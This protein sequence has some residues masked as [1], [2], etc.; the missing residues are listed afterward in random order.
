MSVL[1]PNPCCNKVCYREWGEMSWGRIGLGAKRTMIQN[2]N[3]PFSKML[4][5]ALYGT[6]SFFLS[7][8]ALLKL[9]HYAR[10]C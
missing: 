7:T 5:H 2:V 1:Y 3:V 8:L 9:E 6:S 4:Y 10:E